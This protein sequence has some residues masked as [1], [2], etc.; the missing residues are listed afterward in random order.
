M[1]NSSVNAFSSLNVIVFYL[2][3]RVYK[4]KHKTIFSFTFNIFFNFLHFSSEIQV[5][6]SFTFGIH[7]L[8]N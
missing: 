2:K 8:N 3:I 5:L 7:G 1:F 4:K 6:F